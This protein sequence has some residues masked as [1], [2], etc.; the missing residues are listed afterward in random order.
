MVMHEVERTPEHSESTL[1]NLKVKNNSIDIGVDD[2]VIY[3]ENLLLT[4]RILVILRRTSLIM[5]QNMMVTLRH[6]TV[7]HVK[8]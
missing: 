2:V 8:P 6:L 3:L 1:I 7:N 5:I 4:L